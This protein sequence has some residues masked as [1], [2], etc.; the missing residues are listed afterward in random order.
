LHNI[1]TTVETRS[2]TC[3]AYV[4]DG[5][6]RLRAGRY[7]LTMKKFDGEMV[8]TA[9]QKAALREIKETRRLPI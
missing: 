3:G 2:A 7:H 9:Q 6:D 5:P 1:G 4:S 8:K